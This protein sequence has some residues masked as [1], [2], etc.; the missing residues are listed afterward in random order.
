[1]PLIVMV[2]IGV[3]VPT[4]A[5]VGAFHYATQ[6]ALATLWGVPQE[7]AASYAIVCHAVVFVPIT[8]IGIVLLSREGLSLRGFEGF[9]ES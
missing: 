6:L 3:M 8:L 4:P 2:V 5:A 9:E 1:M 7:Q